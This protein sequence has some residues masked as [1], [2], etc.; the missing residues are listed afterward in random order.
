MAVKITAMSIG[1]NGMATVIPSAVV[2]IVV[3]KA[4]AK[5]M[6]RQCQGRPRQ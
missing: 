6:A 3:G 4:M 1:R 5:A 2:A